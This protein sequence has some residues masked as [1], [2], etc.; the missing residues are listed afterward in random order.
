MIEVDEV[1][2]KTIINL[3]ISYAEPDI[4]ELT[5]RPGDSG[6]TTSPSTTPWGIPTQTRRLEER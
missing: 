5:R 2:N 3:H 4:A 6:Q 1:V